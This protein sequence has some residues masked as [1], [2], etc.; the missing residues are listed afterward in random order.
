MPH[1]KKNKNTTFFLNKFDTDKIQKIAHKILITPFS[2]MDSNLIKYSINKS[3][4]RTVYKCEV[5]NQVYYI[6]KYINT[7]K[8]K[9]VQDKLRGQ[10]AVRNLRTHRKLQ[11]SAI[12]TYEILF[13]MTDNTNFLNNP[14]LIVTKQYKGISLLDAIMNSTSTGEKQALF[15]IFI[16]FFSKLI[17]KRI[18]HRDPNLSN[19]VI[20]NDNI[21]L[22]DLD[23]IFF[24]RFSINKVLRINLI[25]LNYFLLWNYMHKSNI[26]LKIDRSDREYLIK[27]IIR[28]VN[29]RLNSHK[30]WKNIEKKTRLN[31]GEVS[32]ILEVY[33]FQNK[34][35]RG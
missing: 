34:S 21:Y 31:A 14:S 26:Y 3:R 9:A 16:I 19:F 22:I 13:A 7:T 12:D 29:P 10:R 1:C 32:N 5:E 33:K 18:Y 25:R 27:N 17:Q 28:I 6:K 11:K 20:E 2:Q 35:Q 24:T 23:D 4:I 30:L 8:L 15:D